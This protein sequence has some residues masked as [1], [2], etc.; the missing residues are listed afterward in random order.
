[1]TTL[2]QVAAALLAAEDDVL[3]GPSRD[4]HAPPL[5]LDQTPFA[6]EEQGSGDASSMYPLLPAQN[7]PSE[8]AHAHRTAESDRPSVDSLPPAPL[9]TTE[10]AADAAHAHAEDEQEEESDERR[11]LA[12]A[13]AMAFPPLGLDAASATIFGDDDGDAKARPAQFGEPLAEMG[14]GMPPA[15]GSLGEAP[16]GQEG[17]GVP[18][19]RFAPPP[20]PPPGPPPAYR[21]G[22]SSVPPLVGLASSLLPGSDDEGDEPVHT[23]AGGELQ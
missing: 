14:S 11:R 6:Q 10:E 22:S 1:L 2:A 8:G 19:G 13:E 7:H 17:D 9:R 16:L 5:L 18:S 23:A 21:A 4:P 12:A 3:A 15:L 20:G